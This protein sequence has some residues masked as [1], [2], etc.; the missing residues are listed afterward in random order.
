M[1]LCLG[2]KCTI[3]DNNNDKS[4]WIRKGNLSANQ[5]DIDKILQYP[6]NVIIGFKMILQI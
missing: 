2:S 1:V 5:E 3:T 6:S 4:P